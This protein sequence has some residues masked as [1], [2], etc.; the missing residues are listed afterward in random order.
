K[1]NARRPS[2]TAT[3]LPSGKVLVAGGGSPGN[4]AELYDSGVS[5]LANPLDDA[6]FFVRQHY[7]D[8]LNRDPDPA[9]LAFWTNEITSCAGDSQCAEVKRINVSA[10]FFLSIEFQET[11]YFVYRVHKAAYGNLSGAPVP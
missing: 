6:Q 4:T 8:F 7:R 1:L 10:A 3:L 5:S 11:G 9:G 2:H